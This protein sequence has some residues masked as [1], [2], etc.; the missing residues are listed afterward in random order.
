MG[1]GSAD[2]H[3]VGVAGRR[4]DRADERVLF[5]HEPGVRG[6]VDAGVDDRLGQ[7]PALDRLDPGS[8][9]AALIHRDFCAENML[10][11]REGR[12]RVIDNDADMTG[13]AIKNYARG[14]VCV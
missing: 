12:L 10:I 5:E 7:G 1:V 13:E 4:D 14:T 9:P 2:K 6:V 3:L 8:A 11:D